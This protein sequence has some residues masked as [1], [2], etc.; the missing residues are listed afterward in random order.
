MFDSQKNE[1]MH[2]YVCIS[3]TLRRGGLSH[4]RQ[5]TKATSMKGTANVMDA[6]FVVEG[7]VKFQL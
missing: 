6:T 3:G 1:V 2:T 5:D 7:T 4:L